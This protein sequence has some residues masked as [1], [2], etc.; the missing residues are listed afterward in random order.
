VRRPT[1]IARVR[2][3]QFGAPR[4]ER[5]SVLILVIAILVAI[6][7]LVGA[8]AALAGPIF[9]QAEVTRNLN[10]T[11]AAIDAGLEHGIQTLQTAFPT[12]PGLCPPTS[13]APLGNPPTVN[14]YVPIVTCQT[15]PPPPPFSTSPSITYVILTSSP[16][17]GSTSRVYSARA[18]LQVND[19]TGAT[20]IMSWR[21]CQDGPSC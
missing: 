1:A 13:P 20:T 5:G 2:P 11:G 18:V 8:L 7:I 3:S 6:G 17:P 16:S 10:D 14:N 4:D 12:N 19:F 9:A 15:I 21:T